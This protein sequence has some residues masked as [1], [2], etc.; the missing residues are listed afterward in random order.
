MSCSNIWTVY[1][2]P[3][4]G[5]STVESH[6]PMNFDLQRA[7]TVCQVIFTALV[8]P[9]AQIERFVERTRL[10]TGTISKNARGLRDEK[11]LEC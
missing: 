2:S 11:I 1:D 3:R 5:I 10:W 4:G 8:F 9:A 6:A 7:T